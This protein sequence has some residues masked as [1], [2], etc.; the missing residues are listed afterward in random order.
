MDEVKSTHAEPDKPHGRGETQDHKP[1]GWRGWVAWTLVVLGVLLLLVGAFNVWLKESA[2]DTNRWVDASGEYL[3]D[4]EIRRA[5]SVYLVDQ[6][7]ENVDVAG[8]IS[9]AADGPIAEALPVDVDRAAALAAAGFRDLAVDLTDELLATGPVQDVWKEANRLAHEALLALLNNESDQA[10]STTDEGTVVL[11]LAPVLQGVGDQVGIAVDP[12]ELPEGVARIELFQSDE[13]GA[14]KGAVN[15][16]RELSFAIVFVVVGLFGLAIWVGQG[17]RRRLLG[18]CAGG[19]VLVGIL[20]FII[21]STAGEPLVDALVE[22]EGTKPAALAAWGISTSFLVDIGTALIAWGVVVLLGVWASGPADWAIAVRRWLAPAFRDRPALVWSLVSLAMLLVL[23][24]APASD[25]REIYGT[26]ITIVLFGM[27]FESFRRLTVREFPDEPARSG[28]FAWLRERLSRDPSNQ[29]S[30]RI[31]ELE[32]LQALR[33]KGALTE[34]EFFDEK[35][36]T[37]YRADAAR[38]KYSAPSFWP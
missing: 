2:L 17:Q 27:M 25:D 10:L 20:L 7:Y 11:N 36:R 18:A 6:L 14:L 24:W 9:A 30:D 4:D 33:E 38:K 13:L 5:L 22:D 1:A 12:D 34:E 32:R 28:A 37:R 23:L 35:A 16:V 26:L 19:L 21:Q 29:S 31:A 15:A 8:E 3:Q